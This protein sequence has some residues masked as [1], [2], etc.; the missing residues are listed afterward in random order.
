ML[1]PK[2][3]Y[4]QNQR[5]AYNTN[6]RNP[7]F[8]YISAERSQI[9]YANAGLDAVAAEIGRL[10]A[11]EIILISTLLMGLAATLRL[12]HCRNRVH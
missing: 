3:G 6:Y 1:A 8:S 11:M 10:K 9:I 4:D 7:V 12:R 5:A 2:F